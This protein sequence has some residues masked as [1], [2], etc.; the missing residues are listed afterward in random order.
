MKTAQTIACSVAESPACAS[1]AAAAMTNSRFFGLTALSATPAPAA[2]AGR[3]R[4]DRAHP[5][6]H[7]DL[8]VVA[9]P[10]VA[11]A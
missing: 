5:R 11:T 10:A 3:E 8:V 2:L 6:R 9:G 4:I 1:V 7:L